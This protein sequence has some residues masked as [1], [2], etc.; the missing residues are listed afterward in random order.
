MR[1]QELLEREYARDER[2]SVDDL[3][4]I[5]NATIAVQQYAR[6]KGINFIFATHFFDRVPAKR[7]VGKITHDDVMDTCARILTRG[8]TFFKDK[9]EGTTYVFFDKH[10]LLNIAVIKKED[11]RFI[12]MSIVKDYRSLS[13]DQ[14]ITL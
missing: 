5:Q 14:K 11:N 13:R 8:L 2:Y 6:S 1:L 9:E 12:A 10:T 4:K 3:K 7:G